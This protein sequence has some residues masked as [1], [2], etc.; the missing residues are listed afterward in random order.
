MHTPTSGSESL[1]AVDDSGVFLVL[2]LEVAA[3]STT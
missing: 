2:I 3:S 1:V